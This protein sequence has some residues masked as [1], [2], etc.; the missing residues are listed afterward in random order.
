M[1]GNNQKNQVKQFHQNAE[2]PENI[3]SIL[4]DCYSTLSIQKSVIFANSSDSANFLKQVFTDKCF[5][6]SVI[7]QNM[8]P[9]ECDQA[10]N[11]F[12]EGRTRVL[13]TNDLFPRGNE[14]SQITVAFNYGM[15][16]SKQKYIDRIDSCRPLNHGRGCVVINICDNK[17]MEMIHSIERNYQI[18]ILELPTDIDKIIR[19]TVMPR[20]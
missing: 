7:H 13:I 14:F 4:I 17:D 8:T 6:I 9:N 11:D 2:K 19:E 12:R 20:Y 3:L 15:P 1:E 10:L 5:P 18:Q 16:N